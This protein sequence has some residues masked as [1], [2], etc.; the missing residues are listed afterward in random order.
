M[1]VSKLG[2]EHPDS[3]TLNFTRTIQQA[4]S[5]SATQPN[6]VLVICESFS[7]YKSSMWGNPLNTTPYFNELCKKGVFFKNCFSPAYGTARG[8]WPLLPVFRM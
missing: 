8:I 7:A 1:L 5:A 3:N 4:D 6:I 2:V